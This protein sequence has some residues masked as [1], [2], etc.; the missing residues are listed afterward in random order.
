MQTWTWA[1]SDGDDDD[2]EGKFVY[3]GEIASSSVSTLRQHVGKWPCI[4][5]SRAV[6][7]RTLGFQQRMQVPYLVL[8]IRCAS[9]GL[10]IVY[11]GGA[12]NTKR[13]GRLAPQE[14][15]EA[16]RWMHYWVENGT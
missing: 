12:G 5:A 4:D 1:R 2:G 10:P 11:S 8:H 9:Q 15:V 14:A 3:S 16:V 13:Q 6:I 7:D